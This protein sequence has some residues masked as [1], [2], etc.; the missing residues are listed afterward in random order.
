MNTKI[1]HSPQ[2]P[3]ATQWVVMHL[4]MVVLLV[5]CN[6]GQLVGC[7][8]GMVVGCCCAWATC[9]CFHIYLYLYPTQTHTLS[10]GKGISKVRVGGLY[11]VRGVR[12]PQWVDAR[13]KY[14]I[15]VDYKL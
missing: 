4:W 6:A 8:W 2:V 7:W 9:G 1:S 13:V 3:L 12:N 15:E 14:N 11:R 5:G 10:M